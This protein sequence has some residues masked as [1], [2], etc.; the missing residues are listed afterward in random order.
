M[1]PGSVMQVCFGA[2]HLSTAAASKYLSACTT[3]YKACCCCYLF[4]S[5]G[6][7]AFLSRTHLHL[8]CAQLNL[9]NVEVLCFWYLQSERVHC[10]WAMLAVAGI[11]VQEIVR[12]DVFWY[13]AA[14]K[15]D[16]GGPEKI[17]GLVSVSFSLLK[18]FYS[19]LQVLSFCCGSQV[20]FELF[21]MHWCAHYHIP[22]CLRHII[23]HAW[24]C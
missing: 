12:P 16:I 24:P 15:V 6:S 20:A 13:D 9:L 2:T 1:R 8:Q 19:I 14:V 17:L 4:P 21:A 11:L 10:R 23:L 18:H 3:R 7:G 5:S 22:A